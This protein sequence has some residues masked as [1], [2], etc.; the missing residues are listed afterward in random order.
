MNIFEVTDKSKYATWY[1]IGMMTL[2]IA[3]VALGIYL[4]FILPFSILDKYEKEEYI[5]EKKKN[6]LT[7]LNI[8]HQMTINNGKY[9]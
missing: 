2:L 5:E 8:R 9:E 7:D 4:G 1:G 3:L 6:E